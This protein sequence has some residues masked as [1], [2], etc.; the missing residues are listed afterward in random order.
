MIVRIRRQGA[1]ETTGYWQSFDYDAQGVMTVAGMLDELN[2]REEL[3]DT[4][5]EP[6][7]P[8]RWECSCMQ[9]VCGSCAMVINGKPSLACLA[10][11]DADAADVLTVE[12][13]SKFPVVVDLVVDRACILEH[14][15]DA[16]MFLG[17]KRPANPREAGQ[18][19]TVAKC[20][21]C[22][23]CLEVCPNYVGGEGRFYGAPL[24]N[25]AYL[26]HSLSEDRRKELKRQYRKHFERGCSKSLACRDV[27]PAKIATLSSIGYMNR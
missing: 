4:S 27:C 6:A 12:P 10:F 16:L 13:L 15:K 1:H 24:A 22:G 8:I 9:G 17:S 11:I 2:R 18:Q 3:L 20:L 26:L 7:R 14:Q 5:G 19:Y 21:K 25:E 23:L